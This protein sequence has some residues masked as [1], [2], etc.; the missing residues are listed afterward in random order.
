MLRQLPGGARPYI[1][2][3]LSLCAKSI[4]I[5]ICSFVLI[6]QADKLHLV[7]AM[8]SVAATLYLLV[9]LPRHW[10]ESML[11]QEQYVVHLLHGRL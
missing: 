10:A 8:E 7:S 6:L 11:K 5:T 1:P 4:A 3:F 9:S 2:I